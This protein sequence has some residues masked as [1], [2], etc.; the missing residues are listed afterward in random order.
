LGFKFLITCSNVNFETE[1]NL[2]TEVS[3]K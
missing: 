2:K 1:E 3:F